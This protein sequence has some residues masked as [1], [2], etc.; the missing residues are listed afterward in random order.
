MIEIKLECPGQAPRVHRFAATSITVGRAT[1]NELCL[2]DP[3]LSRRHLRISCGLRG[4]YVVE[5]LG[6]AN[7]T[8]VAGRRIVGSVPVEPG[9]AICFGELRLEIVARRGARG[10]VG[11]TVARALRRVAEGSRPVKPAEKTDGDER[12]ELAERTGSGKRELSERTGRRGL[13]AR[14]GAG[15]VAVTLAAVGGWATAW[16]WDL[17]IELPEAVADSCLAED[18][19]LL[20][21]DAVADAAALDGDVEGALRG[22]L[23][24]F[25][26][27]QGTVCA[28]QSRAAAVVQAALARSESQRLGQQAAGL[29]ALLVGD[30][31]GVLGLDGDGGVTAWGREAPGRRVE[32]GVAQ[33]VARG[34]QWLA[35]AG[36]DGSVAVEAVDGA[37]RAVVRG[38]GPVVALGFA[39]D[40]RLVGAVAGGKLVVWKAGSDGEWRAVAEGRAWAGVTEV[41]VAGERVLAF[42][43]G[44]AGVWQ[45]EKLAVPV[46]L[47]TGAA[48]T[49]AAIDAR[50]EQVVAGDAAGLVTRWS[51]GRRS[52]SETLT[53][54]AG[55]VQAVAWVGD[56]VASVGEDDA[57]RLSELG[58]RV[59]RE[60]PPL[61]LVAETPVPVDRLVVGGG[62]RWLIGG[63][64]DGALVRWDLA[65]RSRR[66]PAT[67]HAGHTGAITALAAGG[68][69]VVSGGA[70]GVVR[71]WDL[72]ERTGAVEAVGEAELVRRA[73]REVGWSEVG[74]V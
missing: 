49:A 31:G 53:A 51:L 9:V 50:G 52:R 37:T 20:E 21:A 19:R 26:L 59:R 1:D 54:H 55:A 69:W 15:V 46:M 16:A 10:V 43:G 30:D 23:R 63:G 45:L 62:G 72:V 38:E 34:G 60:G 35:V 58:R 13:V 73:C 70:D 56:A 40:G 5:D 42:G 39:G 71:A 18:A 12:R 22:G 4:G 24:A 33:A 2:E 44:R 6:S 41:V 8:A 29:R 32:V 74:C 3:S 66:L 28:G 7:G 61:V 67:V 48:I 57:L 25:A 68:D 27:V 36:E 65:Q 14:V 64:R 17:P 47:R 11:P